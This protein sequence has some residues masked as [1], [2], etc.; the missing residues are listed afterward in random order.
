MRLLGLDIK[1]DRSKT[2]KELNAEKQERLKV[3]IEDFYQKQAIQD[4]RLLYDETP[5]RDNSPFGTGFTLEDKEK[6]YSVSSWTNACVSA[7]AQNGAKVLRL[8]RDL[9]SGEIIEHHPFLHIFNDKPNPIMSSYDYYEITHS[10]LDLT[11]NAFSEILTHN[12]DLVGFVPM[13]PERVEIKGSKT[14]LIK[15][16]WYT[17][18]GETIKLA[19]EEVVQVKFFNPHDDQWGASPVTALRLAIETDLSAATWNRNFF[20]DGAVPNLYLVAKGKLQRA[21][22]RRIVSEW[23]QRHGKIRRKIGIVDN[24]MQVLEIGRIQKDMEFLDQRRFSRE[25]ILSIFRVPPVVIGLYQFSNASSRSVGTENQI[26]MFWKQSI[27]PRARKINSSHSR[28]IQNIGFGVKIDT[29]FDSIE[30]LKQDWDDKIKNA[31]EAVGSPMTLN[32]IRE[33]ILDLESI[34]GLD[35]VLMPMNM[36]PIG[37]SISESDLRWF[38]STFDERLEQLEQSS[39]NGKGALTSHMVESLNRF[40]DSLEEGI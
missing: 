35:I 22:K 38:G 20:R 21:E 8:I 13:D 16:F 15:E 11:G 9:N 7:I 37:Q 12:G 29:D 33:K 5:N 24:D 30:D 27:L 10:Y 40:N 6:V 14:D 23:E 26:E 28:S 25:E 18:N 31:K 4:S 17:V 36:I 3:D 19:P 2:I 32:E 1:R 39:N 34:E